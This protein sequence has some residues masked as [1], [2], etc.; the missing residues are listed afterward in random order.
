MSRHNWR[1]PGYFGPP[2]M[3]CTCCGVKERSQGCIV[4][5]ACRCGSL[6]VRCYRCHKCHVHCECEQGPASWEQWRK[7]I[8]HPVTF[9]LCCSDE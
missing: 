5:F 4:G 9:G 2:P 3:H 6:F 7:E 8:G 1:L